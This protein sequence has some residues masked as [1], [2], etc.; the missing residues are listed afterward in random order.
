MARAGLVKVDGL[1]TLQIVSG[2]FNLFVM[3]WVTTIAVAGASSVVGLL[4]TVCGCPMSPLGVLCGLW[5]MTLVPLG[6][7]EVTTGVLS[8]LRKPGWAWLAPLTALAELG[9]LAFGGLGSFVV[10][11]VA[12]HVLHDAAVQNAMEDDATSQP[13]L[14]DAYRDS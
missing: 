7:L 2:L 13:R 8:V 10:G 14:S 5:P 12:L 1:A 11:L 4:V 9:S 3:S 6:V